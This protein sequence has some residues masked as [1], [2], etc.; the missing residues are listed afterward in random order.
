MAQSVHAHRIGHSPLLCGIECAMR[1]RR[2]TAEALIIICLRAVNLA[3]RALSLLL[4]A[5]SKLTSSTRRRRNG[6]CTVLLKRRSFEILLLT[7]SLAPAA[8]SSDR[9]ITIQLH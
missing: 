5:A 7:L 8:L 1:H 6:E 3:L 2:S 4:R 9:R